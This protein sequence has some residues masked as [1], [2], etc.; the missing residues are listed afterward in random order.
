MTQIKIISNPY[1]HE[2][3]YK[4]F[5]EADNQWVDVSL[6]SPNGKPE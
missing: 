5:K 4:T 6:Y 2:I 3:E 1:K